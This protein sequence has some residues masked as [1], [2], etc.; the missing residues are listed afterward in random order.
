MDKGKECVF[1]ETGL[2]EMIL[3]VVVVKE[4]WLY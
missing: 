3:V 1:S 4:P 2:F